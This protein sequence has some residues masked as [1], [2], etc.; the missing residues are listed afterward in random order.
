MISEEENKEEKEAFLKNYSEVF[1]QYFSLE[2]LE[3]S[4]PSFRYLNEELKKLEDSS[5]ESTIKHVMGKKTL[6]ISKNAKALCREGIPIKHIKQIL[7]KMFNV[8]F[9]KED[10]ENKTKEVLKGRQF[11]DMGDQVPTF[12]DKT[13]EEIIP[14]NYLN[15]EGI[16]ALKEVL[17]LLNGVLPKME[18]APGLVGLS[19]ILL[20]FL[21]KEETY[22]LV[23]NLIE[24][25]MNPGEIANIRWHFRY[26][27][28]DNIQLYLSIALSIVEIAKPEIVQQFQLI[29]KHGFRR[30]RLVQDM[31]DKF[32]LDYINFIGMIKFL[33]FFLYEGVKG[34]YRFIYG[35]IALS[36]F[37]IEKKPEEK[38]ENEAPKNEMTILSDKIT[39]KTEIVKL[40]RDEVA[41]LYKAV[42]NKLQNW[43]YF[44]E[45]ITL[46]D[47][48]H[49][50]NNYTAIKIPSELRKNFQPNQKRIYIPSLFPDSGVLPSEKLPKLWEKVPADVKYHDGLQ[51]FSKKNNPE[52]DLSTIY[53]IFEKM[54][55]NSLILFLIKTKKEEIFG[56]IMNQAMKLYEDGKYRIPSS[57]N[58]ITVEPEINIYEPKDKKHGEIA[59]FEA[60]AFRFGN[61]EDGPTIT[62]EKELKFGW[63]Q[64][65]SIFGN[66][67]CLLK[68]Y[69][70]DG[71]FEIE[72]FEIY[73]M[74]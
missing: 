74:Q 24:A 73:I 13:L 14:V 71:E 6:L 68:D 30:I 57:A 12:C 67:V 55:D 66:D 51:L 53:K 56:G 42:S 52:A 7:L 37:K 11:S 63:T 49:R 45:T 16:N 48:T 20:I 47:L 27:M 40:P 8:D 60:G 33:S 43:S 69:N 25:D 64:K 10:Y 31:V 41:K 26:N 5:P 18:Y 2:K 62:I 59:C 4:I 54:D 44:M 65:N 19:S 46:W 3:K 22:E 17:W 1:T 21:S 38:N 58:L 9:S 61:G 29:E 39:S 50:N 32:L 23:R 28:D 34:L 15:E 70:D 35:I 36:H 72:D